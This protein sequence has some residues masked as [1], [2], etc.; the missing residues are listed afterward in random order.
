MLV[1]S[2]PLSLTHS[3]RRAP[4]RAI[5]SVSS[6]ATRAP[7]ND[8][9]TT[10][11]RHSR[12]KSSTTTRIRNRLPSVSVSDT[13]PMTTADSALAAAP[14]ALACPTRACVRRDGDLQL[15]LSIQPTQLLVVHPHTLPLQQQLQPSPGKPPPLRRQ[16]SQPLPCRRIIRPPMAIA[17]G[18]KHRTG[19]SL[20]DTMRFA[21]I[22]HSGSAS[23]GRHHFLAVMSFSTALSSI[24]SASSFFSRAF[25]SSSCFSRASGTPCHR[26]STS[27]PRTSAPL[28]CA[29]GTAPTP[30]SRLLAH[31]GPP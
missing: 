2:V 9:S 15:L 22:G 1:S 3:S 30:S 27:R 14:W 12:V 6:R 26:T 11:H 25:S 10:R 5:S 16:F 13:S 19:S 17:V 23:G 7:D 18:A 28:C 4:R 29:C 31:A 24:A 20:A 21:C 8:V